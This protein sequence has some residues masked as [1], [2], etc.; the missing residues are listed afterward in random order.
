VNH[1]DVDPLGALPPFQ[2][3]S[4]EQGRFW[5]SERYY[6]DPYETTESAWRFR[7]FLLKTPT[8][9]TVFQGKGNRASANRTMKSRRTGTEQKPRQD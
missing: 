8:E 5:V 6:F 7:R 2:P 4:S 9:E 3:G 1:F